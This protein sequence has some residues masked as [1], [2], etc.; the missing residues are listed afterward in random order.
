M[1]TGEFCG[2]TS[3]KQMV[4]WFPIE[5][6]RKF[7]S[8]GGF[9]VMYPID[10]VSLV[11]QGERQCLFRKRGKPERLSLRKFKKLAKWLAK[12]PQ[13]IPPQPKQELE[14]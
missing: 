6:I 7:Y 3:F 14:L 10:K 11:G 13:H 2:F 8:S 12:H 1:E 5:I 4:E 9:V